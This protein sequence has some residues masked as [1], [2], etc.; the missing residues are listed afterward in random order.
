MPNSI[1]TKGVWA[2]LDLQTSA[3]TLFIYD[4]APDVAKRQQLV[5][6]PFRVAAPILPWSEKGVLTQ[7]NSTTTVASP[8]VSSR[9]SVSLQKPAFIDDVIQ[10]SQDILQV[11]F[12]LTTHLTESLFGTMY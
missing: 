8:R 9:Q 3:A 12:G 7:I 5:S 11:A 2:T 10:V 6:Y 1:S 4:A